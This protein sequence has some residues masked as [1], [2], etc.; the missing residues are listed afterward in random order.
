MAGEP[1][2]HLAWLAEAGPA[3][4]P[5]KAKTWHI[6]FASSA[7]ACRRPRSLRRRASGQLSLLPPFQICVTEVWLHSMPTI[8]GRSL[9]YLNVLCSDEGSP[10]AVMQC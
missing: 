7:E 5:A 10:G 6:D 8:R 1:R 2:I 9:A 3:A 4:H